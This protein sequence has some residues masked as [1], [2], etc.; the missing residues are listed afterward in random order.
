MKLSSD[1]QAF[2]SFWNLLKILKLL[3]LPSFF[4]SPNCFEPFKSSWDF[5]SLLRIFKLFGFWNFVEYFNLFYKFFS[6]CLTNFD[7]WNFFFV[8][9]EIIP[10]FHHRH[11]KWEKLTFK[12]TFAKNRTHR[13]RRK[14]RYLIR[15]ACE[16]QFYFTTSYGSHP[17]FQSYFPSLQP[18]TFFLCYS[19]KLNLNYWLFQIRKLFQ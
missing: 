13:S 11:L 2:S 1:F 14:L 4:E 10:N 3:N 6:N 5:F 16:P 15:D 9:S 18:Q 7:V 17:C 8:S 19:E 12:K